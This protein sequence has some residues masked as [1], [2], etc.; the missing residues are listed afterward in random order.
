MI[1]RHYWA[2]PLQTAISRSAHKSPSRSNT[3]VE[4]IL[5]TC[6]GPKSVSEFRS[7]AYPPRT[8]V[9]L[10]SIFGRWRADYRSPFIYRR[11]AQS[12]D[13]LDAAFRQISFELRTQYLI[14]YYPNRRVSDSPFRRI[15]IELNKKD[16][17]D[18]GFQVRHRAGY[19]TAPAK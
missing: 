6:K 15:Q 16:S 10:G 4:G 2:S 9:V 11:P 5:D 3:S 18:K 12:I 7:G 1:S 8:V 17:E 14:G 13:Q 19:F